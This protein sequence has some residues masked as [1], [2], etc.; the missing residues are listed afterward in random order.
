MVPFS[1]PPSKCALWDPTPIGDVIGT[2][3]SY[4]RNPKL[5]MAEKTLRLAYRHA[6]QS[7]RKLFSCFLLG[8]LGVDED[9]EGVSLTIDRFDPGREVAGGL[10]KVPT[11]P[12]PGDFWIPC[13][14]NAQGPSSGEIIVHNSEDF[15]LAFK[16]LQHSLCSRD[17]LDPSKLLTVRVHIASMENLDNLN[18]DFH[19]AAVTLA[20]TLECTPVKP[21]PIIPTALARNL[22]SHMNIAQVQGTYK[23]GYLTMD[24]TRKLLLVLESDP[25]AYTLPLVGIWFSGV[26]HV[27]SPEI[28]AC[29]LRYL[30]SSSVQERAFSESRSFLIVLYSLTHKE[31]EFYEC[32][33]CHGQTE[34]GFQLL[35]N[36]E[37][38]HLFK[39]V[40]PLDK[41]PLQFE[42]SAE[43]QNAETKFFSKISRNLSISPP[44]GSSP[45]KLSVSDHDSGVE[46]D[47]S[48]RPIPSPHPACQQVTKICP[49]VPELSIVFDGSFI[50]SKPMPKHVDTTNN[51]NLPRQIQQPVKRS[52][53]TGPLYY[54][55]QCCDKDGQSNHTHV[56]DPSMR[57]LPSNMTPASKAHRGNPS[58]Q[59]QP[60]YRTTGPQTRKS[61]GSSSS[62]SS[63]STPCNGP[64]P[65]TSM[66]QPRPPSERLVPNHDGATQRKGETLKRTL[67][68]NS[69]PPPA[70]T[71]PP[72]PNFVLP[73]LNQKRLPELQIPV[74]QGPPCH[75]SCVC[76]CP[77]HG[78]IQYSP[79]NAWQGTEPILPTPTAEIQPD[80]YPESTCSVFH[81]NMGCSNICCRLI[82]N[83]SSPI[84][85]GHPGKM[86]NC[87]SPL[88]SSLSPGGRVSCHTSPCNAQSCTAA[89]VLTPVPKVES[90]NGM[91]GL[92]LDAYRILTEQDRQLKLLQ[93]Q[94]QRLLEAQTLQCGS[95]KTTASNVLQSEKQEKLVAMETQSSPA[96]HIRKSVS[97]AVSTGASLFWNTGSEGQEMPASQGKPDD[98]EI[99]N[100]DISVS[101]NLERD[102]SRISI[103]SSLKAVDLPSF[104]D[105]THVVEEGSGQAS[106][107]VSNSDSR[108]IQDKSPN[109]QATT[110]PN[111][112]LG[113][114]VSVCLQAEPL[115]GATNNEADVEHANP[116]VPSLQ[117]HSPG[118]QKFYQDLLGHV[119]HFLKASSAENSD[120]PCTNEGVISNE[121]AAAQNTFDTKKSSASDLSLT[122]KDSVLTATLK[123][124]RSLGVNFDSPGKIKKNAY[125]VENASI[126]ACINPKA[127]IPELN[128][129]SFANVGVSGFAPNGA[130]LSMEANA[131]ALKYLSESQ[132]SQLSRSRSGQ[133]NPVDS[134]FQ[135]L[136]RTNLEKSTVGLSLISPNN[137]SFATKKYMKRYG[138]IQCNDGSDDEE[139][140]H[141]ANSSRIASS[142][143]ANIVDP[144]SQPSLKP[145]LQGF[146]C[147]KEPSEKANERLWPLSLKCHVS[148]SASN[149]PR[150]D[151]DG[152]V[153]RNI[154]NEIPKLLPRPNEGSLQ[155][156]KDLKP[157]PKLLAG[158]AEFTQHPDKENANVQI[159]PEMQPSPTL[160]TLNQTDSVNSVGTF[161]DVKHLRQ[162]P[163]LF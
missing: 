142:R 115:E 148:E 91:M 23:W 9:G 27:Y 116:A 108:L 141:Q 123:Q 90:E 98:A 137:M 6:K 44:Q 131:I 94:I 82:C 140:E 153:L 144:I 13:T 143:D 122:D 161:L 88:V 4:Y 74:P 20:N 103:A 128:Y 17:S 26:T 43:I 113:E 41:H 62:S 125:K 111:S 92:S 1:F 11:A 160:E 39:N 96:L 129:M 112:L 63:P 75:P 57:H 120:P 69:K 95:P 31:P 83:T 138:L 124:L 84:N 51:K 73:P 35:T 93:V 33:P 10:R 146:S 15:A 72:Q 87:S 40:E 127:V 71:Q 145:V 158:R 56:G 37:T 132:L 114:S 105:S 52:G 104:A 68:S 34:L 154:T 117:C 36:K 77:L 106:I 29:S 97:I 32:L 107:Q 49:S 81:Q 156:L 136:F 119:N 163:K 135:A 22:S 46:D 7:E 14:V 109:E 79:T 59:R 139:E 80:T 42:L 70:A 50:E 19:W 102:A 99:S 12:L 2:H 85:L 162:L 78:R 61:T 18:F 157:K 53:L 130:D 66:H 30:F 155:I 101:M 48:P 25:K 149:R 118:D 150:S 21:I 54:Q 89:C 64:S 152:H 100:E 47:V 126:L 24:Q 8:T 5:L 86:V 65:D 67:T 110:A 60:N 45:G 76:S 134:S 151:S 16:V 28:W 58:V 133:K 121:H 38:L 55:S 3:L 159:L 147:R